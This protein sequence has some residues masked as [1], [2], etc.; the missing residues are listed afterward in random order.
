MDINQFDEAT[1][2]RIIAMVREYTRTGPPPRQVELQS[3]RPDTNY[4]LQTKSGGIPARS[5]TTCGKALCTMLFIDTDDKLVSM[6]N[7]SGT[8]QERLVW[9]TGTEAVAGNTYIQAKLVGNKLVAD[10]EQC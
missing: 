9:N 4:I 7:G 6:K 2:R 5:G 8:A 3:G 1:M 10:W